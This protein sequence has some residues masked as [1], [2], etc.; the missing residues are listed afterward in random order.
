MKRE[1]QRFTGFINTPSL[2]RQKKW[3]GYRLF[4]F[5]PNERLY[6]NK[7][8]LLPESNIILGKR[9]EHYM[10]AILKK[11]SRFKLIAENLQVIKD[12]KTIGELDY[13]VEDLKDHQ[14]LHIELAYKF[15]LYDP[16]VSGNYY[17]KWIG[18]NRKDSLFLKLDKLINKQFPLFYKEETRSVIKDFNLDVKEFHQE[19]CLKGQLFVPETE[20][21]L[22]DEEINPK[23]IMGTWIRWKELR[24]SSYTNYSYLLL[25]KKDW[26]LPTST[27][28]D[29]K[30]FDEIKSEI[31]ISITM[32]QSVLLGVRKENEISK[33]FVVWWP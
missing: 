31:E 3:K 7:G 14:F 28:S 13:L 24:M 4:D 29:W 15:Y 10:S 27:Y 20:K 5:S 12:K 1:E 19:L 21:Y 32:Q 9:V 2:F 25:S 22:I 8:E 6:I 18:P 16:F 33:L 23:S 11:N 30:L 17:E 26:L